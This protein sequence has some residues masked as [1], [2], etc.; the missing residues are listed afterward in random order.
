MHHVPLVMLTLNYR[1]VRSYFQSNS[2]LKQI[3]HYHIDYFY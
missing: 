2:Y 1:K 3:T